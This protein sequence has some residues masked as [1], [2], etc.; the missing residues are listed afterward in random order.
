MHFCRDSAT[1]ST[2]EFESH[3]IVARTGEGRKRAK[4]RGVLFGRPFKPAPHQRR[5]DIARREATRR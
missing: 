3:L 4:A 2:R 1:S 5:E